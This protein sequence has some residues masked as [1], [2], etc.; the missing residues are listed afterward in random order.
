[1]NLTFEEFQL[2]RN[3]VEECLKI[4]DDKIEIHIQNSLKSFIEKLDLSK[5]GNRSK[6]F[7]FLEHLSTLF[8]NFDINAELYFLGEKEKKK[9]VIGMQT[10]AK[11]TKDFRECGF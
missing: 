2:G 4:D 10:V 7:S 11:I 9:S 5:L 6:I 3:I 1:M 8:I